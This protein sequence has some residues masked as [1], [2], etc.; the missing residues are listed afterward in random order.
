MFDEADDEPEEDEELLDPALSLLEDFSEVED[1][2]LD[3][4]V[5]LDVEPFFPDLPASRLSV[6]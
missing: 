5:A 3:L 2:S 1:F 4:S 6:R